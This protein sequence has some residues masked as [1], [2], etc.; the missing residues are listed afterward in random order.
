MLN[1]LKYFSCAKENGCEWAEG[2]TNIQKFETNGIEL[3]L[4]RRHLS[5]SLEN[6]S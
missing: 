6:I 4:P 1:V 5:G 3:T 2:K